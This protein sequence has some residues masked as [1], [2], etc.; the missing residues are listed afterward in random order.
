M[1]LKIKK[2]L[3]A[4]L[5]VL[6]CV[7]TCNFGTINVAAAET[8]ESSAETTE[9]S[10][11]FF[12]SLGDGNIASWI[13]EN[14]MYADYTD[15]GADGD[16]TS[17]ENLKATIEYLEAFNE[18]RASLGLSE[19]K[20]ASETMAMAQSNVN[21]SDTKMAH[22][23][24]FTNDY[25]VGENLAW[26][27]GSDPYTQWYTSE[28]AYFDAAV[29]SGSFNDT[30]FDET[31]KA[32][33]ASVAAGKGISNSDLNYLSSNYSTFYS[34]VG[35]YLNIIG[36]DYVVTGFAIS[37]NCNYY[38]YAY[39]QVFGLKTFS[40]PTYT[41]SE[42]AALIE[43]YCDSSSAG[44][45]TGTEK[46]EQELS[47]SVTLS[48]IK[49]GS[50]TQI[51][52]EQSTDGGAISYSSD[53]PAVASVDESGLI[54]G[55]SVGTARIT[56]TAAETDDY[57][58]AT[59]E[60][61]IKVTDE[62]GEMPELS[63]TVTDYQG[64]YDGSS[65][66]IDI[67]VEGTT[68]YTVYY[69]TSTELD[70]S[71]YSSEGSTTKSS[72]SYPGQTTVYYYIVD[73]GGAYLDCSGVAYIY[74]KP[75][76]TAT[77]YEGVYTGSS[78]TATFSKSTRST[79]YYS[80]EE[81][82]TPDNY[83]DSGSTTKPTRTDAGET[84]IYYIAVP[85]SGTV[86]ENVVT[87]GSTTITIAKAAQTVT[88]SLD[89]DII[90]PGETAQV[91]ASTSGD[92]AV[93][94]TSSDTAIAT[95]NESGLITGVSEGTVTITVAASETTNYMAGS[96]EFS[97][98]VL[99]E[100]HI[101][102]CTISPSASSF[103]YTGSAI[104]PD[105]TVQDTSGNTLEPE[106]DYTFAYSNNINAGT[107]S[108]T[109][110]GEGSWRGTAVKEFTIAKAAQSL[111][112]SASSKKI[113]EGGTAQITA[114][115]SIYGK[116]VYSSN[117]ETV[118]SVDD[119][120]T[121]TGISAGS[122]TISVYAAETENYSQSSKRT[123]SVTV[124]AAN[125]INLCTAT[126]SSSSFTYD[127][128][129][130]T[131]Q[132]T[133]TTADGAELEENTDYEVAYSNN[134]SAGT[135]KAVVT[136]IGNYTG[137]VTLSF[138]INKGSMT[139]NAVGFDGTYDGEAHSIEVEVTEG[140]QNYEI[141]YSTQSMSSSTYQTKGSKDEISQTEAG[142]TL[143]Y[144]YIVNLD[145]EKNYSNKPGS[146]YIYIRPKVTAESYKGVYDGEPHS[147][148]VTAE[149]NATVYY[150]TTRSL[151]YN[152]YSTYGSEE[153]PTRTEP[154]TTTVYYIA[155]PAS[156]IKASTVVSGT[157]TIDITKNEPNLTAQVDSDSVFRGESAQITASTESDS[158]ISFSSDNTAVA[159]VDENGCITAGRV[160]TATIT[161]SVAETDAYEAE[162]IEILFTVER[163]DESVPIQDM[164]VNATGS[165]TVY[166]GTLHTISL[167]VIGPE[168][169][170][171][172][173][174]TSSLTSSNYLAKG[175][176]TMPSRKV[177]GSTLVY[178]YV[179]D[180][181]GNY[182]DCSG[183]KFI[184]IKPRVEASDTTVTY[185]GSDR[186]SSI[187]VSAYGNAVVYY[188]TTTELT[189]SNYDTDGKTSSLGLA[190]A[191]EYTI[192][193]IAVPGT[194][195]VPS[196]QVTVTGTVKM[197]ITQASQTVTASAASDII[198]PGETTQ[199]T[200]SAPGGGTYS[201]VS[202]DSSIATVDENGLVTG[203]S[204]G[205]VT[206]TVTA[207]ETNNYK[208]GSGSVMLSVCEDGLLS[209]CTMALELSSYTYDGTE[210]TPSVTV[211]NNDDGSTLE[212]GV[213]YTVAY[214]NN[215]NVGT[216]YATVTG[217]GDYSGML[218]ES[219]TI[220]KATM[221]SSDLSISNNQYTYD[222]SE[223]MFTVILSGSSSYTIYYSLEKSLNSSNYESYGSTDLG[224]INAGATRVYFYVKDETGNYSSSS[225]Y[226]SW[227]YIKPAVTAQAYSGTYDGQAHSAS[228]T[229]EGEADLYYS[230]TTR[231]TYYNY[232]TEGKTEAPTLTDAGTATVYY[233]A[234]PKS[235]ASSYVV[236][237]GSTT[238]TIN[239]ATPAITASI[240]QDSIS[241]GG[242][243]QI[244]VDTVSDGVLS[245][246]S[247]DPDVATVDGDGLV[248][249]VSPGEA[250]ITV[251][252]AET[253]NCYAVSTTFT[254]TVTY[255]LTAELSE[256]RYIYDGTEKEPAVTVQDPSGAVLTEGTD[257]EV[258]YSDNLYPGKATA[259]ITGIGDYTGTFICEFSIVGNLENAEQYG[260]TM[261]EEDY[262]YD[263]TAKEPAPTVVLGDIELLDGTDY[264]LSY[265]NNTDPGTGTVTI[266]GMGYYEG[267]C[268]CTFDI[269]LGH[270]PSL[271]T[272]TV[273]GNTG[274]AKSGQTV[275]FS[276]LE[277][278]YENIT[279]IKVEDVKE[280]GKEDDAAASDGAV[281]SSAPAPY[282]EDLTVVYGTC[283]GTAG[284]YA[285][286]TVSISFEKYESAT[287]EIKVILEDYEVEPIADLTYTG[288]ALKPSL[289]VYDGDT[290]LAVKTH[291]TLSYKN[292]VKAGTAT[293]TVKGKGN[294]T[295]SK[296]V[297]FTI[298]QKSLKDEDIAATVSDKATTAAVTDKDGKLLAKYY[299]YPTLKYGKMTLKKGTDYDVS[300]ALED[301]GDAEN[302]YEVCVT[303]TGKGNYTDSLELTYRI[304]TRN[305]SSVVTGSV[306]AQ[307]WT[308]E[309]VTP[310]I[311]VYA[312]SA[313]K[314]SG[315]S[316]LTLG[317]DY[318]VSYQNNTDVGTAKII[319]TGQGKYSGTK[320]VSFK[321]AKKSLS[322]TARD[323]GKVELLLSGTSEDGS[324]VT[325][326]AYS[327]AYDGSAQTPY[328]KVLYTPSDGSDPVE[329]EAGTDYKLTYKNNT[330]VAVG[331]KHPTVTVTAKGSRF[332]GS[333]SETFTI[334]QLTLTEEN[335]KIAVSDVQYS[336]AVAKSGAKPS[337]TV[338]VKLGEA[339]VTLKAGT[340]YTITGYQ[341]QYGLGDSASVSVAGC[342][343]YRTDTDLSASFRIYEDAADSLY[344]SLAE[345]AVELAY[346]GD[347]IR[348]KVAVY[349][350]AE[351]QANKANALTELD[352]GNEGFDPS[353]T[354]YTVSYSN[355]VDAGKAQILVTGWGRYGG[356]K[357]V[358][359]TINQR[360][361]TE[362][363]IEVDTAANG[364][365]PTYSGKA[366]KLTESQLEV[367]DRTT[368]K[369][370]TLG[371]DY[372]VSY[373]NN[374]N[375]VTADTADSK[376]P[377]VT[378]K[379]KGN[380]KGSIA[381][382]TFEISPFAMTEENTQITVADVRC[383]ASVEKNGAK[384]AVTVK[385]TLDGVKWTTLKKNKDYTFYGDTGYTNNYALGEKDSAEAPTVTIAGAGNYSTEDSDSGA[386]TLS[387]TFRIYK[388]P[389]SS[390]YVEVETPVTYTG[391][392]LTPEVK[393]YTANPKKGGE[394]LEPGT[395]Y[396]LSW[397]ENVNK[398]KGCVY[399][400][401][402]GEYGGTKTVKLTIKARAIK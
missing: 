166:D 103:T 119:S 143:V 289:V 59:V 203:V 363:A 220:N 73:N 252:A 22:S 302:G 267:T 136:G 370:L 134:T 351:D 142:Y 399:I 258:S 56:V 297:E 388:K 303:I 42:Y 348:P 338:Q 171:I 396:T 17:I 153:V 1:K 34:A 260:I 15:L 276:D 395:D 19:L 88:A 291:Y 253:S 381:G 187:N 337:V 360:T 126:M 135:A 365:I 372:T 350:S 133:L 386:A 138:T 248:T 341:G 316:S 39:S 241:I 238:I 57:A 127:G 301:G 10:A 146:Q 230:T 323:D 277:E 157:V 375:A 229:A 269:H 330:N 209:G 215:V 349:A 192:Y 145:D 400:N 285:V 55:L 170:T 66:T 346:T 5:A 177:A 107:A 144:Y 159:S 28:K 61:T 195:T 255:S 185:N 75:V 299:S 31:A 199:I 21:Y 347:E 245:Y 151:T 115:S 282:A 99:D 168:D 359:F 292:N 222:G 344:V 193:Y 172:Y 98:S 62:N 128:S 211:T 174:S 26:N 117:N 191:G 311:E 226:S 382:I 213:D 335:T 48:A 14:A 175:S 36:T 7:D 3:A 24:Q 371:T 78:H 308:G 64:S 313:E 384:P 247:S 51:T 380:Y 368:G 116:L 218:R 212:E 38:K 114:T 357:A 74:I 46:A 96:K 306:V 383:S 217:I 358:A 108:I 150:S 273:Y 67:T 202:S 256:T 263:G 377:A 121:I 152:N 30:E 250:V 353:E 129:E 327:V 53:N 6:L 319:L 402:I 32:I 392:Q 307:T 231:L 12:D 11:D 71:N 294:Y 47:A 244:S 397:R 317:T 254:V 210:K 52:V 356:T 179:V 278:L 182:N 90:A 149:G 264:T 304:A 270:A 132:V 239:K 158:A 147:A 283:T 324:W 271:E 318:T 37:N 321:I 305:I 265:T 300:F 58:K 336:D 180:N 130:K 286:I 325:P 109:I 8:T 155:V 204:D 389:V 72:S 79:L 89:S 198:K 284:D 208:E 223:H 376:Y 228:V 70:S 196:S 65:H 101:G 235:G 178:Y 33:L 334:E 197:T 118:A 76:V 41:V 105:F 275:D 201:Y 49:K 225:G 68:D 280:K 140:P 9:S 390:L 262:Y 373:K 345:D 163:E 326:S 189:S 104:E 339:Y 122:A 125:D 328:V 106:T 82:L 374:T 242:T 84:T 394:P 261:P 343:N 2:F 314:K 221:S 40:W 216:A 44:T 205:D 20:V 206:I 23:K 391:R 309:E 25:S 293:A 139:V 100:G 113:A 162:E 266:T 87:A 102:V 207:S 224:V 60:L 246:A 355:N 69:S 281:L 387:Q 385:V 290:L 83:L 93:S 340:G 234:V 63:A 190:D 91:T 268:A 315:V 183:Y 296:T 236:T 120:G 200:A 16:A 45:G 322:A 92:G 237:T 227:L 27:G 214:S 169:Y 249:A 364:E 379:G 165:V 77:A 111:T 176:E 156:G 332:S 124:Y 366:I 173:Y 4:I 164:T 298:L 369:V 320:T 219:F 167:E 329:L 274:R 194:D 287:C 50:S 232:E 257:Y 160:G 401:G 354:G 54:E 35:H 85:S 259:T 310:E 141:Y 112:I 43:E 188:S 251:K 154:G 243:A 131:P 333:F 161:V 331:G 398:G 18:L 29:T 186:T 233:I 288:S 137:T 181:D 240:E 352:L 13:L 378:V 148:T 272:R 342:G 295:S 393:V 367:R 95:V 279:S 97:L 361:L 123:L 80:T 81:E 184:R 86:S 110:T 362:D 312:N 94:Y